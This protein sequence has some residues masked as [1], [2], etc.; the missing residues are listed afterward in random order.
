MADP[1]ARAACVHA[2]VDADL[3]YI[4]QEA[5]IGEQAQYD[6]GQHYRTVKRFSS[7]ADDRTSLGTALQDDFQMRPDSAQNR[8]SIAS[9][10]SA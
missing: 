6:M 4:W 8:A 10:V 7:M 3:Q 2:N 5:G 1:Q 9:V